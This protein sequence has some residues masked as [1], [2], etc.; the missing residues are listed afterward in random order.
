MIPSLGN[1]GRTL[2]DASNKKLADLITAIISPHLCIRASLLVQ[3]C[4]VGNDGGTSS[5]GSVHER[6]L[7]IVCPKQ[8][9]AQ[10]ESA[11][12][13]FTVGDYGKAELQLANILPILSDLGVELLDSH[14][15]ELD[16]G[17][18]ASEGRKNIVYELM[19]G[20]KLSQYTDPAY[21]G[22]EVS[23]GFGHFLRVMLSARQIARQHG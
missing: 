7:A 14:G 4:A 8:H 2:S 23:C 13:V 9:Q 16:W 11:L 17:G 19:R 10:C 22:P 18:L 21:G 5:C 20:S 1:V 6:V 12:F 15:L 3:K